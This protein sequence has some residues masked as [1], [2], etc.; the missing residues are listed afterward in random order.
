[1][2][3]FPKA[4]VVVL[5]VLCGGVLSAQQGPL[6][7]VVSR[8]ES[9]TLTDDVEAL[10]TLYANETAIVTSNITEV[11]S[12]VRFDDGQRLSA[13]DVL[14]E[15]TNREQ[16]AQLEEARVARADA[17]RQLQRARQLSDS[18]VLARQE[19]DNREREFNLADARL[20][21]VEARLA[22]R[23]VRAPF[24]SVVGLRQVSV[25]TLLTPGMPVATL[26]DDSVM[27]LDFR[28]PETLMAQVAPGQQLIATTRAYPDERFEG[29][30]AHLDNEVDRVTRSVRVRALIDNPQRQLKPGMLMSVLLKS[31]EREA[32]VIPEE[33][34]MPM[35]S[36]QFVMLA[37]DDGETVQAER[38]EVVIGRRQPGQV[39][40]LEGLE[41]GQRVITHGNFR[42]QPAQEIRIKAELAIGESPKS[43]LSSDQ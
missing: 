17:Q 26:H 20:K 28:L 23:L 43:I 13:G 8:V 16:L 35:G 37:V 19:L 11:I 6:Q 41:E 42:T 32:L 15:L 33:A 24:D 40:V 25:G 29:Q 10:G 22:D 1:M 39:E 4:V 18:Q 14:V 3:I 30:V 7:V 27:K 5:G 36:S 12:A 9:Q 38:R 31:R 21:A 34:L 2:S